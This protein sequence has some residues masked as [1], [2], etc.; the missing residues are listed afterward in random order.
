MLV[1]LGGKERTA[2]GYEALLARAR[3]RTERVIPTPSPFGIVEAV[4]K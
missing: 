2:A 3:L 4:A 1:M